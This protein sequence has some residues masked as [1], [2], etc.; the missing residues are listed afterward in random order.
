LIV[1]L[2]LGASL[3]NALT[4]VY[5]RLGVEDA[6]AEATLKLSLLG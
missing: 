5:Q 6:P 2:A 3:A 1:I 4:S